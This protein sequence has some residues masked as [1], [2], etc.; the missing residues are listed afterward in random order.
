[1]SKLEIERFIADLK[2]NSE[3]LDELKEGSTGLA[4]V[5]DYAAAKGYAITIDD[6]KAYIAAQA[7]QDLSDDQIDAI[8]AGKGTRHTQQ[9]QAVTSTAAKVATHVATVATEAVHTTTTVAIYAEVA[10]VL[11]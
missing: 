4:H 6:A 3:M 9:T 2:D 11:T 10:A 1:M 7:K 8:A 5:V